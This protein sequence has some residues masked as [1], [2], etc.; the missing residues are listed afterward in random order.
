MIDIK[1]AV[2]LA[3]EHF[4]KLYESDAVA[5][6]LLEESELSDDEKH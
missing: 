3:R 6:V 2:V 4:D 1:E 5:E